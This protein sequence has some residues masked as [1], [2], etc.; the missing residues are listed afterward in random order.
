MKMSLFEEMATHLVEILEKYPP[1]YKFQDSLAKTILLSLQE[2]VESGDSKF[3][4]KWKNS[5]LEKG[6]KDTFVLKDVE[7]NKKSSELLN[8]YQ[9]Y[10]R[11][12][13]EQN[14]IDFSDMILRAI[15]LVE[16]D[17]TVRANISEQ[18]QWILLDEYQDTN[19]AQLT[20]IT[21]IANG[22]DDPNIFAV[23]D[24]DQSIFKFQGASVRNLSLFKQ[25]YPNTELIILEENYRSRAEI[26]D[27]SRSIL[28]DQD[29][30]SNIF[31]EA[32]KKFHAHR[33][34]GGL[35]K[36]FQ[37]E[38]ELQEITW[39]AKE[40]TEIVEHEKNNPDF[41][42]S[43][44]AIITKKNS[45]LEAIGKALLEE[46]IPIELSKD[47]NI[48]DNEVVIL[49][50]NMLLYIHS[51]RTQSD[52]DDILIEILSHPMWKIHRLEIW[53]LS[54]QIAQAKK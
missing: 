27:F 15:R 40:I 48:F 2:V 19:D 28:S 33:G 3:L 12:L 46:N 9:E 54:R 13:S 20:L 49:V 16:T 44:I 47:E 17:E 41:S 18:Y 35:I 32:E 8:I 50:K 14:L 51:L 6:T 29:R 43:D 36:K 45:T 31:P 53:E 1:T 22:V 4:T 21:T 23:G 42:L 25:F 30:I 52:R 24:D 37:F 38:T 26:I 10:T 34:D 5:W 7:K 11:K 39:V